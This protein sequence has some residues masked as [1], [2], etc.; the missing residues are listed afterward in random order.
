LN[1]AFASPAVQAVN[2]FDADASAALQ[3][4]SPLV[5]LK[6]YG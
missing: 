4:L 2:Q 6:K 1:A 5:F 3:L